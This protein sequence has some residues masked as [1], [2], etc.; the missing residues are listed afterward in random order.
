MDSTPPSLLQQLRDPGRPE[1]WTRFV[2]LYT[3]ML[4]AWTKRLGWQEADR[5]DLVQEVLVRLYR[6]LPTFQYDR[7][8]SFRRWLNTVLRNLARD[9]ARK[10]HDSPGGDGL[11][12]ALDGADPA[13]EVAEADFLRHLAGRAARLIQAEFTPATY[14]A[15]WATVVEDRPVNEV[16]AQLGLS[17]NSVYLARSRVLARL[18]HEL[19][20]MLD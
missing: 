18:R 5:A 6:V 4:Y 7:Q 15:F 20:G 19:D 17:V 9:L 11:P 10:R 13:V 2:D 8:G 1:A 14:Q 3:P 16:A 12:E